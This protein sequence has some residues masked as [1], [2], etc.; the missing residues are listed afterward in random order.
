M[1]LLRTVTVTAIKNRICNKPYAL[2][3]VME[4]E[5]T[6][7]DLIRFAVRQDLRVRFRKTVPITEKHAKRKME[8]EK[9][10]IKTSGL[11]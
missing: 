10:T 7:L 5:I 9:E 6:Q 4:G 3:R 11:H 2:I 1:S 8:R